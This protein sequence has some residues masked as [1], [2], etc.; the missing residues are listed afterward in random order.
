MKILRIQQTIAWVLFAAVLALVLCAGG[1]SWSRALLGVL[2][3]AVA[4]NAAGLFLWLLVR[5]RQ[6][7]RQDALAAETTRERIG[8]I[9]K[10]EENE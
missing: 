4:V 2:F 7:R 3:L 8:T 10:I 9:E 5:S 6:E 1:R